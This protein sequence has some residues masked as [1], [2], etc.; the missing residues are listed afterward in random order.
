MVVKVDKV[1][2]EIK[3][4][5]DLKDLNTS[6]LEAR[7][8]VMYK[9][10]TDMP[11]K[12]ITQKLFHE[13]QVHQIELEV[14]N[15]QLQEAQ[16][17]L[18][19]A[20]D[21][22]ADLY[23]FAPVCYITF[24]ARGCIREIN[25]TGAAMLGQER[26][27][28][29]GKPFSLWLT[30]EAG[31]AFFRHLR[32]AQQGGNITT[33]ELQLRPGEGALLDV[34]L[35]SVVASQLI[36]DKSSY[37]CIIVNVS[38]HKQA[39]REIQ[40]QARQLRLITDAMPALIAYVDTEQRYHCVNKF[41]EEWFKLPRDRIIGR[42]VREVTGERAYQ[43]LEEFISY[44]LAGKPVS[45]ETTVFYEAQGERDINASYIPDIGVDGKVEGYFV[46]IRDVTDS[47]RHETLS[48]MRLLETAHV[49]RINTMGEMVAEIAHEL[50]QP[51]AAITIYSDTV[52]RMLNKGNAERQ[53]MLAA[54]GE[55]KLQAGRASQVISRLRE[56]VSKKN[57][58]VDQIDI[59]A[60]VKEVLQLIEVEVRWHG[61]I[62]K[63][64]LGQAI[65]A[66]YVDK[67]LIEQV[68][69]NLARN[70]I[71]AM[72]AIEPAKRILWIRTLLGKHNEI[73]LEVEDCGPG[74]TVTE[75][76]QVFEPFYS[77]KQEGMGMGLAISRS[78]IKA[79]H[80]RLW[81]IPNEC[82]GTTFTFTLPATSDAGEIRQ[83]EMV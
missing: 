10:C 68:I 35:E 17:Q 46:L 14:Q 52:S 74:L 49:A 43:A 78:I 15:R 9:D 8:E 71:E 2:S 3:S 27:R 65:P 60:L 80:G 37:R 70:A 63:L 55:I 45:F 30:K 1:S 11:C 32:Q 38:A 64:E 82:G 42:T 72:G 39:E 25:L 16:Q 62:L 36:D 79:H 51:L 28:L 21:R 67:I 7:F 53:D 44:A 4:Q 41:Y 29:L 76:E 83:G 40:D 19:E 13:L 20:R 6:E 24:D 22:Y 57:M 23:D 33:E 47:R 69:M 12:D 56:F 77:T 18:E 66:V 34:R 75:I 54:L 48:K 58:Q 73:G 61:V 31:Q 81:A 26:A 5:T 59:N 50:N